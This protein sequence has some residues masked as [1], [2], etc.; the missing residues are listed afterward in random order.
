[1]IKPYYDEDGITIYNADCREVLGQLEPVDLVLTSP[2]YNLGNT[3][4][5]GFPKV[6]HY[7]PQAGMI[8]RGGQ[9]KWRNAAI[10]NGY[11]AC[12]DSM[13]MPE[14][15]AWQKQV[16]T[17]LWGKLTTTGA[18]YYNHKPRVL[19]GL[20]LLPLAYSPDLP[21]RQ[22]VIWARAGG[23]N[24][25]PSFY[26]P[27]HEWLCI[28]AKEGFRLRDKGASGA[29]DVWYIPQEMKNPHPAPFPLALAKQA[30]ST[31]KAKTILDP[32]MGSGTTLRAAKDLGLKAIGIEIEKKYCD[33]AIQRLRQQVLFGEVA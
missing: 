31:T 5:G 19:D 11:G 26:C 16:L 28:F 10:A 7:D 17:L 23:I 30:I 22:V 21:L 4:G 2:P 20:V 15:I 33:I 13:P 27:T 25:S 32:F 24:F 14:Y 18:I 12:S 8:K 9:G 1:M 29:G 6:G 3:T